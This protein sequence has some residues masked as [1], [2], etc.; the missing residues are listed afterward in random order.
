[1]N[2]AI[3]LH[4]PPKPRI[5]RYKMVLY[6]EWTWAVFRTP[7]SRKP[8]VIGDNFHRVCEVYRRRFM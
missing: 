5:R 3:K 8:I 6:G 7:E 1:M 4:Q 2:W